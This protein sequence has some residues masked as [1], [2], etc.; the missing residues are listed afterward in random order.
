M[1]CADYQSFEISIYF[2]TWLFI[3]LSVVNYEMKQLN[4][5]VY[6]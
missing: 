4:K 2:L 1:A 3:P 6:H 5:C